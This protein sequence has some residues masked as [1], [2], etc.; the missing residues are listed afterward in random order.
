MHSSPGLRKS[1][2]IDVLHYNIVHASAT[3]SCSRSKVMIKPFHLIYLFIYFKGLVAV[4][5]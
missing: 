3:E 4:I 5:S 2:Q 1:F